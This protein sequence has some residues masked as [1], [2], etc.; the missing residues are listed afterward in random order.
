MKYIKTLKDPIER[1]FA[2]DYV[3]W[4]RAGRTGG[5]PS[6]NNVTRGTAG[7]ICLNLFLF[8]LTVHGNA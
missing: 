3:K 7:S 5:M 6:A 4:I 2:W 1:D 8:E